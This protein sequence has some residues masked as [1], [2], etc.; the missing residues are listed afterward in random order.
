MC[1]SLNILFYASLYFKK[2]FVREINPRVGLQVAY[3]GMWVAEDVTDWYQSLWLKHRVGM[4]RVCW[5]ES[6]G[7][8]RTLAV[9]FK[10]SGGMALRI[11]VGFRS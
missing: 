9:N 11:Y 1:M 7:R 2:V 6:R 3:L 5:S 8:D 10:I 4:G